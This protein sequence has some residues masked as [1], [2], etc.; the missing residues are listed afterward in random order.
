LAFETNV[1]AIASRSGPRVDTITAFAVRQILKTVDRGVI[2]PWWREHD[3][4]SM[5]VAGVHRSR[6]RAE[7]GAV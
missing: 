5:L 4:V 7:V 1:T 3:R 2:A 6:N